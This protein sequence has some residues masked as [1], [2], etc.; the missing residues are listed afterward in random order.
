M[1]GLTRLVNG[2]RAM[3]EAVKLARVDCVSAFP[4]TPQTI[5]VE[6]LSEMQSNGEFKGEFINVESEHSAPSV[7]IG[8]SLKGYRT[9]TASA[10]QGIMLMSEVL[11]NVAGMRIPIVMG[12][13]N[14]SVSAP[15]NIHND[16]QDSISQRDS[17][18][19]QL[20]VPNNQAALDYTLFAFKI[21]EEARVPCMVCMDGFTLSHL[22]EPVTFP[23]Q[24]QVDHFLPG[25]KPENTLD[26]ADPKTFGFAMLQEHYMTTRR[27]L[28]M[29]LKD[30]EAII[31]RTARRWENI[32]NRKSPCLFDTHKTE[33][34]DIILVSMGSVGELV[35][36]VIEGYKGSIPIGHLDLHA[37]RPFPSAELRNRL[38]DAKVIGVI[39]RDISLGHFGA[40]FT[41]LSAI[42]DA[43]HMQNYI[44]GL[45]GKNVGPQQI[46]YI[47][48]DLARHLSVQGNARPRTDNS[49]K[50]VDYESPI[51]D[52]YLQQF[53]D[54][55]K[56]RRNIIL[57]GRG[58]QGAY[59]GANLLAYV[60]FES[61][62]SVHAFPTFGPER[63]GAP[64]KAYTGMNDTAEVIGDRSQKE[65]P[66]MVIVL[67]PSLLKSVDV[68]RGLRPDGFVLVNYNGPPSDL[69]LGNGAK[70]YAIDAFAIS[71]QHLGE[72]R[73]NTP[74]VGAAAR[75]L[76]IERDCLERALSAHMEKKKEQNI[77]AAL[78][79]YDTVLR[80][81]AGGQA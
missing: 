9:F 70:V 65:E 68:T 5:I 21:A 60:L 40:L 55:N 38:E 67:D 45:G 75:L 74:L 79:A 53:D 16:Q 31:C 15:I 32:F 6:T 7:L 78:Q 80:G 57:H 51:E 12:V 35:R 25:F 76:G 56:N 13:S 3:A 11:Y 50:F 36:E 63:E 52:E 27:Q 34:A 77:R 19:I 1:D 8:A 64:M 72:P 46:E 42:M 20:Y 14:R 39:D 48:N 73:P 43:Q 18:W 47:I 58:G 41:D 69:R 17:G 61:G 28:H 44:V 59:T 4:I 22:I 54:I 29:A 33:K 23:T 71:Q 62:R 30:S 2:S 24:E 81:Q 49:P 26:P 66:N 37:Y 10:S